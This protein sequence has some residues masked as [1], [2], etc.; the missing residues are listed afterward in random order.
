VHLV[1]FCCKSA[2]IVIWSKLLSD[3][4]VA[5]MVNIQNEYRI[6]VGNCPHER[7]NGLQMDSMK[8]GER[9]RED[10]KCVGFAQLT[11]R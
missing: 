1:G 5:T 8:T 3:L 6:L 2:G 4:Q 7:R 11:S 9:I 10:E